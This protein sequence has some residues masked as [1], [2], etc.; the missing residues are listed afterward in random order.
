MACLLF[1]FHGGA[2]WLAHAVASSVVHAVVYGLVF[3]LMRGLTLGEAVVLAGVVLCGVVVWSRAR[4][5]RGY[6]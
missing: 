6:W 3:R 5:R 2:D 4:G 1:T